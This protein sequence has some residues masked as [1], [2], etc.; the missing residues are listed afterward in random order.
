MDPMTLRGFERILGVAIGGVTIVLGFML[1]AKIRSSKDSEGKVVLPGGVSIY[2]TRVGP[3]T[4]FALFGSVIVS[5]SFYFAVSQTETNATGAVGS[6]SAD[7]KTLGNPST[8]DRTKTIRG[9]GDGLVLSANDSAPELDDLRRDIGFLNFNHR[10]FLEG[11]S[12][13]R[14]EFVEGLTQ[15]VKLALMRRHWRSDWGQFEEF[16]RWVH[17]DMPPGRIPEFGDAERIF[18]H[19]EDG[20]P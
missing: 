12:K 3:G 4:F 14:A 1:F 19:E 7:N 5:L 20:P 16:E 2:L 17:D 6:P 18:S 13:P 8:L 10:T 15:R 9:M 11:L